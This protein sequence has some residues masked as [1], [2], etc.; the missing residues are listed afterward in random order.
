MIIEV[1]FLRW[2]GKSPVVVGGPAH[3]AAYHMLDVAAVAEQLLLPFDLPQPL[4]EALALMAGL[5]DL[6]KI[7]EEFYAVLVGRKA[8]QRWRHWEVTEAHLVHHDQKLAKRLGGLKRRRH[9]LYASVAGHHGRPPKSEWEDL[10]RMLGGAG[11]EAVEDAGKV[12]DAF[13]DLWPAASLQGISKEQALMLSWWLPGLVAAADW[14]GSNV[15]WFPPAAPDRGLASYLEEARARAQ[16]AV[17]AAGLATP[18]VANNA[19]Y[20]FSLRRMQEA[21]AAL[22]ISNGPMLAL[23]EDETGSGKTEAA[24]ILAHRMIRAGK[25]RGLFLALPTMATADAMF[26]RLR[27]VIGRLYRSGPSLTLAHGRAGLSVPFRDLR[28][29]GSAEADEPTCSAWL[30]ESRRRALLADVGVGTI[31]QAL[32]AVLPT[33]HASLR[34]FGLSSKILVVD[35]VH[36]MGEPYM[37]VALAQLLRAHAAQE[38]SAILLTATLPLGLRA[39]LMA[40]F[41]AGAG[42]ALPADPGLAYPALT[43]GS[44]EQTAVKASPNSRGSVAVER[45]D[46]PAAVAEFLAEAAA[47]RA[48]CVWVRNAVDEAITGVDALRAL[49]VDADLLHAR[50]AFCD[51]KRHEAAALARFGKDGQGRAGRVLVATQVVEA[52]LDLDFDVMVSDLAPMAALI[53]RAGRLWRHMDRRPAAARPVPGPVLHVLSPDPAEVASDRWLV[54]TLGRGAWVYPAGLQWRTARTLFAAGRIAAPDGLRSLIEAAHGPDGEPVPEALI[55]A[56]LKAE[57]ERH[58]ERS[59]GMQN[60]LKLEDGFRKGAGGWE[61]A[62]YPTRLGE[63]QRVLVLARRLA[64]GLKPWAGC[65]WSTERAL[66]SEVQASRRRLEG[67]DLPDQDRPEITAIK[68]DWPEWRRSAALVCPVDESGLICEGL[69]YVAERGLLLND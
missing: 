30:A 37:E 54:S 7:G 5:H 25:A 67:L 59:L 20:D 38:G 9:R 15:E 2:A 66:L 1:G 64:G 47:G 3:P 69:Y 49:G 23:I 26:T 34:L 19:L 58:A 14:I 41:E 56:D 27:E 8:R 24:L 6:G 39:R 22:P 13:C 48:A 42:R 4:S 45:L 11:A 12:I 29:G 60:V 51:R 50:F 32:L 61:D 16:A 46:D 17:A 68:R 55:A 43:D 28:R 40:A 62:D 52:S 36:E 63:R 21:A 18:E 53:Q 33:K 57:G 44:G 65:E 35:E 31:D 10:S